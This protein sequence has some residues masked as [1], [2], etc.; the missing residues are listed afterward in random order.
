MTT[1]ATD[2]RV[3]TRSQY[4]L[5][6]DGSELVTYFA[7][8]PED[9]VDAIPALVVDISNGGVQVLTANTQGLAQSDYLLELVT[10]DTAAREKR[11]A[12]RVVWSRPNGVN[13]RCG[14]AFAAGLVVAE[15]TGAIL[16][17]SDHRMLRCVLYPV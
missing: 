16:A 13:T 12:V 1:P 17:G 15:E 7:F 6:H 9:A 11:Y 5:V 10:D 2:K 14:L 4:F 8:R 3:N